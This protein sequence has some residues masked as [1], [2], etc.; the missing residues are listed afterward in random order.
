LSK[1]T[2]EY[3][4]VRFE[5]PPG[6]TE[7]LLVRHGE[8]RAATADNPFPL[9]DGHGD[10]EL[11][12]NGREQA[13]RV[14]ERLKNQPISAVYVSNLRRTHET[15]APLCAH[16]GLEPRVDPDLREVFL[17]EWEGGL[18]RIKAHEGDPIMDRVRA[19]R[20]WD[21]IPGAE[22]WD[23]LTERLSRSLARIAAAHPDELVA[24]FVHGGVIG[25]IL[26][27]ATGARPFSFNGA[28]NGSISH[29]VMT[30]GQILVRRFNDS[31]HLH[32]EIS[33]A[34]AQMT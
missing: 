20:R 16:I 34:E 21:V 11:H 9:V 28:D 13:Q 17:G 31:T 24:A 30:Q 22:S 5:R 19:E 4:Q 10:P 6:A 8:S 14:G 3:R 15:A 23:A 29:I 27:H 33:A 2:R 7:I 1:P 18:M 12:A 25:H 26:S 32:D